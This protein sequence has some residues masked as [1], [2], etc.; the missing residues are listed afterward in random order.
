MSMESDQ[1]QETWRPSLERPRHG[2]EGRLLVHV[3]TISGA[4]QPNLDPRD[5]REQAGMRRRVRMGP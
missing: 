5:P 3:S 2:E 1:A 4:V